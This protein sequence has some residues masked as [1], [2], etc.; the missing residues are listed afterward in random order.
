M[1]ILTEVKSEM[2]LY[3]FDKPWSRVKVNATDIGTI[4]FSGTDE[5]SD[6]YFFNYQ[7][8]LT[9]AS[10][11]VADA[12]ANTFQVYKSLPAYFDA[13]KYTVE[14]IKA[15][16]TDGTMIPYFIIYPKDMKMTGTN[17]TLL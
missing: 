11:Y 9:P 12:A 10:L 1:C 6:Q 16:S 17:P 7:N 8:F 4:G 3:Y 2:Y 15:K 14:Q 5:N 13:S